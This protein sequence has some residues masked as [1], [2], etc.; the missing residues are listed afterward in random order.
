MI[1]NIKSWYEFLGTVMF[2]L[3]M[4]DYRLMEFEDKIETRRIQV[5]SLFDE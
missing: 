1:H 5:L 2:C 3:V 4:S